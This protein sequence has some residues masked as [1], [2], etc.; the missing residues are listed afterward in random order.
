MRNFWIV[1][2]HEYRKIVFQKGFLIEIFGV[3]LLIAVI[4]GIS[5]LINI[6]EE[7]HRP[8]GYIDHGHFIRI[9]PSEPLPV[10]MIEF[11]DEPA[12]RAALSAQ[13]IQAYIILPA[14]Y[15]QSA[16]LELYYW[17][18]APGTEVRDAIT[19]FLRQNLVAGAPSDVQWRIMDGSQVT[20]QSMD[21]RFEFSEGNFLGFAMPF[22]GSFLLVLIVTMSSG[23]LLQVVSDE[24]ENRTVE[25]LLTSL[26]PEQ[27]IGGKAIG[28]I[29]VALTIIAAWL[30]A[31]VAALA[32]A[33]R[34][35]E[36]ASAIV[37][38][39]DFLL[40]AALFF[41]PSYALIAGIMTAVGGSISE[42]RQGQQISGIIIF[43]FLLPQ[44]VV[45]LL[46]SNPNSPIILFFTFFPTTS[47]LMVSLRW[48]IEMVPAWQLVASWLILSATA[49]LSVW[50][51][52]RIFRAG[53]LR[54]GQHL[55][56]AGL[57]AVLRPNRPGR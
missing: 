19:V 44:F 51:S 37:V 33:A 41:V 26:S 18:E 11:Q 38:P 4:M 40:V 25:I 17:D 52:A 21:G 12:A 42:I 22:I 36:W 45:M 16:Q 27:L 49:F 6:S 57:L 29:G 3:P 34:F 31:V 13:E 9:L 14:G 47:F 39:W 2:R 32:V 23:Y 20:I 15:P 48:G 10:A 53:M 46:F 8:V 28:L 54:Y 56:F 30:A 1:A 35:Y 5:I 50:A 7:D 43:L 24:K 55:D